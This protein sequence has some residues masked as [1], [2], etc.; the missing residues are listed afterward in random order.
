M[1]T[2][3]S[4]RSRRELVKRF[5]ARLMTPDQI[6]EALRTNNF[7]AS[8]RTVESDLKW[9]RENEGLRID[10]LTSRE[11]AIEMSIKYDEL[12]RQA[13]RRARDP[14]LDAKAQA[15]A[16]SDAKELARDR[17]KAYAMLI[18]DVVAQLPFQQTN[19]AIKFGDARCESCPLKERFAKAELREII[20]RRFNDKR[21]TKE[22]EGKVPRMELSG[23]DKSEA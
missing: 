4:I 9:I 7:K 23:S 11:L 13:W 3:E 10:K 1:A 18:P 16:L 19:V 22:L 21:D 12:E 2:Q 17:L 8:K 6:V 15:R 14:A 20:E 5:L